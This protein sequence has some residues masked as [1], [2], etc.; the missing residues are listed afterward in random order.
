METFLLR[1]FQSEIAF[2]CKVVISSALELQAALVTRSSD[3]IW[4]Q[5]QAILIASASLSKML[6]GSGGGKEAERVPLR[7]SL[8]VADDSPIRDVDLRNDFEHFD[9]RLERWFAESASHV[10]MGRNIGPRSNF[11]PGTNPATVSSTSI[12]RLAR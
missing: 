7:E 5:L 8:Q 1:I 3:E 2:Q 9:E 10:Y 12:P 6:W 11:S 4:K